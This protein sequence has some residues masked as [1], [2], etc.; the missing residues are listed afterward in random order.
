MIMAFLIKYGLRLLLWGALA[1]T[2]TA[3]MY[4]GYNHIYNKGFIASTEICNENQRKQQEALDEKLAS[5][6]KS[7]QELAAANAARQNKLDANLKKILEASRKEPT[8][9]I[10]EGVCYPSKTFSNSF[11]EINRQTNQAIKESQK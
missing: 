8:T 2:L 1:S 4:A 10:Q 6:F 7:S 5:I 9:I 11:G 3:S